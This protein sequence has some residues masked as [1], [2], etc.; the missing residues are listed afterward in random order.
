MHAV[1]RCDATTDIGFGHLSRCLALA[2]AF[3]LDGVAST[4]TGK[5]TSAAKDQ[6]GAAGFKHIGL[7]APVNGMAREEEGP[8]INCK[9]PAD[10][11]VVDSYRADRAYLENLKK[12]GLA[13]VVIDDF[14]KLDA[15]PCDVIV[16]FTWEAPT[17]PYPAG[18]ALVL[19]HNNLLTRRKLVARRQ[20]SVERNRDGPVNNLLVAIGGSDP[21]GLAMRIVRLL[22]EVDREVCVHVLGQNEAQLQSALSHFA[23]GS[24]IVPRQP[25]LSE[26]LLWADAAITGGGL[27]KYE[28]AYMGVPAAAIAQNEG[29]DGETKVF[30]GAGLAFDLGLADTV[31]DRELANALSIFL[32]DI[33]LR[34]K[35]AER[36]Q[37]SFVAD[38]SA[39]AAKAILEA[40]KL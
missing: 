3:A 7:K 29:Q 24:A 10:F 28:S 16:N 15:Y 36:M 31:A 20:K 40:L 39:N 11:V 32:N 22:S 33:D 26:P 37:T 23:P 25:D 5:F 9:H 2:E 27:I 38:P 12:L 8:S 13:T 21:K 6:I 30:S 17:L 34:A 1:F 35:M 4:F 18:P 14:C 19:G